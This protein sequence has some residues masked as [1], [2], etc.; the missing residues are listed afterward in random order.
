MTLQAVRV[1][2]FLVRLFHLVVCL[3][4]LSAALRHRLV[5]ALQVFHQAVLVLLLVVHLVVPRRVPVPLLTVGVPV[6]RNPFQAV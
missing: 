5:L 3:S 2:L 4:V 6:H 1:S